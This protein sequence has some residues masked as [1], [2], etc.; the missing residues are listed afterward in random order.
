MQPDSI[1]PSVTQLREP[2]DFP[3]GGPPRRPPSSAG[4]HSHA[5]GCSAKQP[6]VLA[7]MH[8]GQQQRSWLQPSASKLTYCVWNRA[9]KHGRASRVAFRASDKQRTEAQGPGSLCIDSRRSY[10]RS[11]PPLCGKSQWPTAGT[12]S[13]ASHFGAIVQLAGSGVLAVVH[14]NVARNCPAGD[15]AWLTSCECRGGVVER[16]DATAV[17][18]S[19][20]AIAQPVWQVRCPPDRRPAGAAFENSEAFANVSATPPPL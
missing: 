14:S 16:V 20:V 1:L 8:L 17:R 3:P 10:C 4:N 12:L 18:S 9:L 19:H 5:E 7:H 13:L 2:A 11:Q 15:G 6:M